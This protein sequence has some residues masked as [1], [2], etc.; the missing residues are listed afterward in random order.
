[1]D[2]VIFGVIALVMVVA[3]TY[4]I[5]LDFENWLKKMRGEKR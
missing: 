3:I 5:Y 4:Q 2:L 1:M